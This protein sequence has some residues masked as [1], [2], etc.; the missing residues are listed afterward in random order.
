[1]RLF[2]LATDN[3]DACHGDAIDACRGSVVVTAPEDDISAIA[4]RCGAAH[5]R[6]ELWVRSPSG[7]FFLASDVSHLRDNDIVMACPDAGEDASICTSPLRPPAVEIADEPGEITAMP[8]SAIARAVVAVLSRPSESATRRRKKKRTA[9]PRTGQ[10][11]AA[12]V[13]LTFDGDPDADDDAPL[14]GTPAAPPPGAS[15]LRPPACIPALNLAAVHTG[16]GDGPASG[17][18][19]GKHGREADGASGESEDDASVLAHVEEEQGE[20]EHR[21]G[22]PKS[23][24]KTWVTPRERDLELPSLPSSLGSPRAGE[25]GLDDLARRRVATR[26][27]RPAGAEPPLRQPT[28]TPRPPP[29]VPCAPPLAPRT[30]RDRAG[31]CA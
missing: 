22:P 15:G 19:T 26:G 11:E 31:A 2:V 17:R 10:H 13:R 4:V 9:I 5:D 29:V 23:A 7:G 28:T 14:R 27:E 12:A 16:G 25:A 18:A 24:R 8:G 30:P 20:G 21:R 6:R 1:M 3:I